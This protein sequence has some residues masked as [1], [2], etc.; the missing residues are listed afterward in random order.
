MDLDLTED[1]QLLRETTERFIDTTFPLSRVRERADAGK[2]PGPDYGTQAAELGWFAFLAPERLGGGSVSGNGVLDAVVF[3]EERGKVLQPGAF[4]DTNAVVYALSTAGSAVQQETVLPS[5]IA[6]E[7]AAV[8][9]C[10]DPKGD[11]SGVA[12]VR[13]TVSGAGFRLDGTKGLVVEAQSAAWI[14][15][16]AMSPEGPTQ[17]LLPADATGVHIEELESLDL[18]R[19]LCEITFDGVRA[20]VTALVGE[21]GGAAATIDGQR[22]VAI[23]LL[24][25]ETVGAMARVF[26]M[27]LEYS[28]QRIAFGRPIGSFQAVK[29]QLADT[30]LL[31][32]TS[33]AAATGAARAAQTAGRRADEELSGAKAF[34]SDA[35]IELSHK[36]WQTFGGISYTWEYDFHLYMRRLATDAALY[37][38]A[39]WHREYICQVNGL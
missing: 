9:A 24:L 14:L 3:A 30:S 38:S 6:G 4:V 37:G 39:A 5:L 18:S 16:S 23:A 19:S 11:W 26:E 36:C 32:E 29:H 28:K 1:Q 22:R 33:L 27:T 10:A 2:P 25:S 31:L 17:F 8:W 12:G 7:S 20:E 35:A 13:G 21:P 15:V 34:I